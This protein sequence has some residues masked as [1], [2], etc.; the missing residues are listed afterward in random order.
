MT[1][2]SI[3]ASA[4]A[5]RTARACRSASASRVCAWIALPWAAPLDQREKQDAATIPYA[6]LDQVSLRSGFDPA[7]GNR[8]QDGNRGAVLYSVRLDGADAT[9]RRSIAGNKISLWL[10][11]RLAAGV[12]R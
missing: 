12:H 5:A 4:L 8:R 11:Q 7:G 3:P 6:R 9:D 2:R 1:S 10:Q